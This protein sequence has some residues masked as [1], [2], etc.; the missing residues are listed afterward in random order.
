MPCHS[1]GMP[2]QLFISLAPA[3]FPCLQCTLRPG[4][5]FYAAPLVFFPVTDHGT[6]QQRAEGKAGSTAGLGAWPSHPETLPY[7]RGALA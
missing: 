3:C 6:N 2:K 1:N 5:A 7:D 4:T